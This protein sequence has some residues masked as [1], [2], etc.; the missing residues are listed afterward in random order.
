[1]I[2]SISLHPDMMIRTRF[3]FL[4]FAALAAAQ[5]SPP[6]PA[7]ECPPSCA[8][9]LCTCLEVGPF[10]GCDV[11]I[12]EECAKDSS[13]CL[14][15]YFPEYELALTCST[16]TC[17]SEG[18]SIS[19][20]RCQFVSELCNGDPALEFQCAQATC[21][22]QAVSDSDRDACFETDP[23]STPSSFVP[24]FSPIIINDTNE[25]DASTPQ[26]INTPT[27]GPTTKVSVPEQDTGNETEPDAEG[28][29]KT[30]SPTPAVIGE[31]TDSNANGEV[32]SD[33]SEPG[34]DTS[35]AQN[36]PHHNR[37]FYLTAL[38]MLVVLK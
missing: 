14:A 35:S 2:R 5:T 9:E 32:T 37:C 17:L 4:F 1:M 25:T 21:C 7:P 6:T 8:E 33:T 24:T 22:G 11:T 18:K 15:D 34:Q 26:P 3:F 16:A 29:T 28:E 38:V 30:T 19:E 13:E 10:D 23:H 27:T 36:F 31:E 12:S 20:C